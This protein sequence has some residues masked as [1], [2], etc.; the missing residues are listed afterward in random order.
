MRGPYP[1]AMQKSKGPPKP[2]LSRLP[3]MRLPRVA[4]CPA[5]RPHPALPTFP[6]PALGPRVPTGPLGGMWSCFRLPMGSTSQTGPD[7]PQTAAES[8]SPIAQPLPSHQSKQDAPH[9]HM[10]SGHPAPHTP[11]A[12]PGGAGWFLGWLRSC[13]PLSSISRALDHSSEKPP[14]QPLSFCP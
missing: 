14:A 9:A 13:H 12:E 1:T 8:V 5:P 7:S 4:M 11:P 10:H 2:F 3:K 6:S